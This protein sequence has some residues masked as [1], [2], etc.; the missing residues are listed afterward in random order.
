MGS[1]SADNNARADVP[2]VVV[3]YHREKETSSMFR[4][5]A[6]VTDGYG[7]VVVNNGYDDPDSLRELSTKA[8]LEN[9]DNVGAIRAINQGL[10]AAQGDYV[11]VL[12]NDIL[13]FEEGWLDH[14]I[15]FMDRRPDVGL[16]GLAG[17]HTINQDG[18]L[19]YETTVVDMARYSDSFRPTWRFTEVAAI[20]GLGWVMRNNG[21]RLDESYGLMHYYD[22]D[23]SMQFLEA[24]YRVYSASVELD[25]LAEDRDHSTRASENYLDA[26]GGDDMAYFERARERFRS[27]WEHMLPICRGWRDEAYGYNRVDELA[28]QYRTLEKYLTEGFDARGRELDKAAAYARRVEA[29]IE[30]KQGEL[31][32][33][34]IRNEEFRIELEVATD[35]INHL[36][37]DLDAARAEAAPPAGKVHRLL[38]YLGREGFRLT[39]RRVTNRLRGGEGGSPGGQE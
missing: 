38:Y 28:E 33:E 12:H 2:I 34:A 36:R 23:L 29:E 24:G 17:R 26:I 16:V 14:I 11:C 22:I 19:D 4:Q 5:L 20:D 7:L 10:D 13:I 6:R 9:T 25:H 35:Q 27:K 15:A 18:T 39:A 32:A 30:R 1:S 21:F 8:Y 37:V 31:L 3:V